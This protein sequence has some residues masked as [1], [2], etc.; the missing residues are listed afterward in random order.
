VCRIM[1][2]GN[3]PISRKDLRIRTEE[4]RIQAILR[5][6]GLTNAYEQPG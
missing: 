6:Y 2:P 3:G 4:Y 1:R 5:K